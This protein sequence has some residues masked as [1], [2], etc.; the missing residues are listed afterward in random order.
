QRSAGTTPLTIRRRT[1]MRCTSA[2]LEG[3]LAW[4][5]SRNSIDLA[6][7]RLSPSTH[8]SL[9]VRHVLQKGELM[10]VEYKFDVTH[11]FAEEEPVPEWVAKLVAFCVGDRTGDEVY[12]LMRKEYP[13]G[14]PDF[15]AAVKRLISL[16]VLQP[17]SGSKTMSSN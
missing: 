5:R 4:E 17:A 1:G 9:N 13:I 10:P 11:P 3:L 8:M 16:G 14:R 2:E 7:L 12:E 6:H 15:E